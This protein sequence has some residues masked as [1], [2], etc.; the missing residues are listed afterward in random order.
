MTHKL[1]DLDIT[2]SIRPNKLLLWYVSV[3]Y[4]TY[5]IYQSNYDTINDKDLKLFLQNMYDYTKILKEFCDE[6]KGE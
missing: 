5:K 1:M 4:N 3:D 2:Q 6:I